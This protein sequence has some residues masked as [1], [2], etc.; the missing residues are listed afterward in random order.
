[1]RAAAGQ[2]DVDERF[3]LG[4]KGVGQGRFLRAELEETA[5]GQAEAATEAGKEEFAARDFA[6][7]RRIVVPGNRFEYRS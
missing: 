6:E 2:E 4:H 3:R 1:M 7:M 5:E